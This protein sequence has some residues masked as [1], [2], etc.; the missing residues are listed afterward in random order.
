[1]FQTTIRVKQEDLMSAV[2]LGVWIKE[3]LQNPTQEQVQS[4]QNAIP[5]IKLRSDLEKALN[6][7][8]EFL[9]G[10][11]GESI[12]K[13][14]YIKWLCWLNGPLKTALNAN[15][16]ILCL[17]RQSQTVID[18]LQILSS[19]GCDVFYVEDEY[20]CKE[21]IEKLAFEDLQNTKI[22]KVNATNTWIL[23]DP[24]VDILKDPKERGTDERLFYNAFFQVMGVYSKV[25]YPNDL[26]KF[27]QNLKKA[28]RP[29][30]VI[31]GRMQRPRPEEIEKFV[32][33]GRDVS[34]LWKDVQRGLRFIQN[35][36]LQGITERALAEQM[37]E[38]KNWPF[39]KL[40]NYA[41]SLLVWL[42]RYQD[43]LFS[44]KMGCVIFFNGCDDAL[45]IDFCKLLARIP[46]DVLV[47]DP[48]H[49]RGRINDD[50]IFVIEEDERLEMPHFP[51]EEGVMQMATTAYHAKEEAKTLLYQGSELYDKEQVQ[52]A[53]SVILKSVHQEI[54]ELWN[55]DERHRPYF[56]GDDQSIR[57]PV[58]FSKISGVME[59]DVE[60]YWEEIRSLRT[61]NTWIV[62]GRKGLWKASDEIHSGLLQI[63]VK[64][65]KLDRKIIQSNVH[66]HYGML[67]ENLQEHILDKVEMMIA[68]KMI[69]SLSGMDVT[70][71]IVR[72]LL[73]LDQE[74]L[75]MIQKMDF[76]GKNPKL[77]YVKTDDKVPPIEDAIVLLFL[78]LLGFDVLCYIPTGYQSVEKYYTKPLLEECVIGEYMYDLSFAD[79][80][81]G[82]NIWK[83]I[84]Q[85]LKH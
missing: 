37:Q 27:Y 51:S 36:E 14:R 5:G 22:I 23:P 67:R 31:E 4:V 16:T 64:N 49:H 71:Q 10:V 1:M 3:P 24:F 6:A 63:F 25:S 35:A 40:K 38:K 11:K 80:E 54:L 69:K 77:V 62:D 46:V 76:V 50:I 75:R 15:V 19:A 52:K 58:I 28:N 2:K 82:E 39:G 13:N 66:Y 8:T 7:R 73:S 47:L 34:S 56:Y 20:A 79:M 61:E 57:M 55:V 32:F 21:I 43:I 85:R 78:S 48:N 60:R 12:A 45:D 70:G 41:V 30:I 44:E 42:E 81:K 83:K 59:A 68:Q 18:L 65:G 29:V 33:E 26:L 84:M 17:G 9:K 74:L 72:V 53:S